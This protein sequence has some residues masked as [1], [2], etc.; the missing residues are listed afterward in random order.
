M[1]CRIWRYLALAVVVWGLALV[2]PAAAQSALNPL[3]R[4]VAP[5]ESTAPAEPPVDV[6]AKRKENAELLRVAQRRLDAA[7]PADA[8]AA[9]EIALYKTVE[10]ILAQQQAVDQ[11]TQDL[12]ARKADLENQLKAA[13]A[14]DADS[15]TT[16]SFLEL[17]RLKDEL[18]AERTRAKSAAAKLA[19]AKAALERA[20][21]NF[22][23]SEKAHRQA[24]EALQVGRDAANA[25]ELAAAADQAAQASKL[26]EETVTLRKKEVKREELAQQVQKLAV[27]LL[28]QKVDRLGTHVV[29]SDA[30]LKDQLVPIKE[31]EVALNAALD[32]AQNSM[33]I[34]QR[35][36]A[37]ARQQLEAANGDK[38][39]PTEQLEAWQRA[40]D[41][42]VA[43]I[44]I[45]TRQLQRLADL[46]LAWN[47]RYQLA[48]EPADGET[49]AAEVSSD[50]LKAWQAATKTALDD[51]AGETSAQILRTAELRND[52]ATV[53]KKA[54][55]TKDGPPELLPWIERQRRYLEEALRLHES[56]LIS[57]ESARRVHERL[58]SEIGRDVA[59]LSAK[60]LAG[61]AWDKAAAFWNYE[62]ADLDG[63]SIQV[64]KVVKGLII[65]VAGWILARILSTLF[66][67]RFLK[68]FRMSKDATAAIKTLSFYTLLVIVTLFALDAV[69]IPLT[70]FTILGG[71]LAIG[72]GFGSQAVINNFISG[73]IML[74]ER[75]VRIGERIVFGTYDGTVEEVG[76]RSTKVRTL[77][78]HLVTIPNSSMVNEPIENIGRRRTIRRILHV[79]ITYDTPRDKIE[80]AVDTIR[81]I[82]EE[83]GIREPIHPMI[84]WDKFPPRVFFNDYNAESLNIQVVYWYAP[85]EFW[86]Y[87]E[88]AQR[89]NLRIFEEFERLGVDFAFPSRTLYLAG[90]AKRELSVR[91]ASNGAHPVG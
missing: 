84:G 24:Q 48:R 7:D 56:N 34:V 32:K 79:T 4:N 58:L 39:V 80:E 36:L 2:P 28:Q 44:N 41:R 17:D 64:K 47:R 42:Y 52:L 63:S 25:A 57:I 43:E 65:F 31:Q 67:Y 13:A 71:A 53:A 16:V 26:A 85:P 46:R 69:N 91:L 1:Q 87:M 73:L 75:P 83:P 59:A 66:A 19:S 51:L 15:T 10:A 89:V 37:D 50:D 55:A 14:P 35:Q 33:Q 40:Y 86:D 3:S 62:L 38:T 30:N 9:Q 90:D 72:V 81:D 12:S 5:A 27:Q 29:F 77:T 22:D 45:L 82:L 23:A 54:E 11:Q 61:A 60:Q 68:R 6:A 49:A 21:L 20:Q 8:A 76:F 88:H 78:D 18:N 74:A 70:A